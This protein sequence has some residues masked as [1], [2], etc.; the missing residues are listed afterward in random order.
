MGSSGR[1]HPL[2]SMGTPKSVSRPRASSCNGPLTPKSTTI[3]LT[4]TSL[5]HFSWS[6]ETEER[7]MIVNKEDLVAE[8]R[9]SD[10]REGELPPRAPLFHK[11]RLSSVLGTASSL[12]LTL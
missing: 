2:P 1:S 7:R 5:S 12:T 11:V 9:R 4:I 6:D 10:E 8:E 3:T